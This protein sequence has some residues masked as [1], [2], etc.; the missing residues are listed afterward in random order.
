MEVRF[1]PGEHISVCA[2]RLCE[3]ARRTGSARGTF[4]DIELVADKNSTPEGI[5]AHFDKEREAAAVRWRESD[6]G[7]AYE[8]E[9]LANTERDQKR[10]DALF[11]DLP[12]LNFGNVYSL[13]SWCAQYQEPSDRVGVNTHAKEVCAIFADHGYLPNVNLGV[14]YRADDADNSARYLIGQALHGLEVVGAVHGIYQKFY[15]EWLAKF[16]AHS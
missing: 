12:M 10:V 2:E 3:A 14:D 5:M 8:A 11:A 6:A 7:K 4:N 1:G 16:T 15:G 9:R 13:L